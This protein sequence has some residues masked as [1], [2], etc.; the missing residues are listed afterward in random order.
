MRYI[1]KSKILS[2]LQCAKRAWLEANAPGEAVESAA[3]Q[4]ASR[5]G[6][7]FGAKVR[8]L[9]PNGLLVRSFGND[10]ALMETASLR[11]ENPEAPLFEAA[12]HGGGVFC[13]VDV[14]MQEAGRVVIREAKASTKVKD[15]HIQDAAIQLH[16]LRSAGEDVARVELLLVN[17][18]YV[19]GE[20]DPQ[21]LIMVKDVTDEAEAM[22]SNVPA[23]AERAK[24]DRAGKNPAVEMGKHCNSPSAC[25]FSAHC[26]A[27]VGDD[28]TSFLVGSSD[29]E[30]AT[31]NGVTRLSELSAEDVKNERNKRI[32]RCIQNQTAETD[33][34][35]IE[36]LSSLPFPRVMVDFE[37]IATAVPLWDGIS[38]YQQVPTQFSAHIV[39]A[40]GEVE[41]REY[42]HRDLSQSPLECFTK[43]LLAVVR[44][45][46]CVAGFGSFEST[47]LRKVADC[48]PV[49]A[50]ELR[51]LADNTVNLLPPIRQN[52]YAPALQGSWS[53]KKLLPAVT[54]K[55]AYGSLEGV[56]DGAD[57]ML[58]YARLMATTDPEEADR[59]ADELLD[60]CEVDTEGMVALVDAFLNGHGSMAA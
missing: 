35:L 48:L 52:Y 25:P 14:L 5:N 33:P 28:S 19:E 56:A 16:A 20:S 51:Q 23:W 60:Y 6:D 11:D 41:H 40:N 44:D 22:L 7:E 4:W 54:G 50:A 30:K 36:F 13:R 58:A 46:G 42:L 34:A 17:N 59:L 27:M 18:R 55:D 53:I 39:H 24:R 57:A 1:T 47:V 15:V 38:P 49:Y 8:D 2:T 21:S 37:T 31:A 45:A 3:A 32:V 10:E 43:A 29:A 12:I 9:H 26:K